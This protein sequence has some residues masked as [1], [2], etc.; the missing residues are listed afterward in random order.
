MDLQDKLLELQ[1]DQ[2]LMSITLL[3]PQVLAKFQL[4][5]ITTTKRRA[6]IRVKSLKVLRLTKKCL[7]KVKT[8]SKRL[9]NQ[10]N[11][12]VFSKLLL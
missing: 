10:V 11:C 7:R 9:G 2:D 1:A 6:R 4:A 3:W 8:S 12:K 5:L